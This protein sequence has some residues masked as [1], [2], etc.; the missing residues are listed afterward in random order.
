[1][2]I[3]LISNNQII[4]ILSIKIHQRLSLVAE[5]QLLKTETVLV[6]DTEHDLEIANEL[7]I[8]CILVSNGR[9]SEPRLKTKHDDVYP[10]IYE[11]ASIKQ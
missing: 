7:G 4:E 11:A 9:H 6:G 5:H 8:D 10:T 1:M 2:K 3:I